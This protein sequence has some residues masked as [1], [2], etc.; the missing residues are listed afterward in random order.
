MSIW[1][2]YK[3]IETIGHGTF[4]NIYMAQNKQTKNYV[5]IKEFFKEK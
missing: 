4:G 3:N 5:A 1:E 2:K